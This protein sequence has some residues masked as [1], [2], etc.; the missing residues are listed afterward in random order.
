[1]M[2][3]SFHDRLAARLDAQKQSGNLKE[4]RVIASAIAPSINIGEHD[5]CLLFATND[6]LSL[7]DDPRVKAASI[8]A[9]ERYGAG[10][11]AA[12]FISG[13]QDLHIAL[14]DALASFLQKERAISFI[15]G[16]SANTGIMPALS[17]P[18]DVIFADQLNHASLIDGCRLCPKGVDIVVY[19]HCDLN[20]LRQKIED[21]PATGTRFIVTDG[22]FSM[23]GNAAPLAALC[24]LARE[25]GAVL[26]VDDAHG[27]GV[28]GETGR[29]AAELHGCLDQVDIITGSLGKA[30]GGA[31]GGFVA[32]SA[33]VVDTLKEFAR[34]LLFSNAQSPAVVAATLEAI[35]LLQSDKSMI[36]ELQ[37]RVA[38][39]KALC[40]E[41]DIPFLKTDSAIVSI[42]IGQASRAK[43]VSTEL[44]KR[45]VFVTPFSYP[46]VPEGQ[47]RLRFQISRRQSDD[48]LEKAITALKACLALHPE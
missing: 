28:V 31:P 13:T 24:D 11:A 4:Q 12:R 35:T 2:D 37:D 21:H 43:A 17:A 25:K 34:P 6:Y 18:G 46:V 10:T 23:E 26:I 19:D 47:A 33:L 44:F 27:I 20:N 9:I 48:N 41:N 32:G 29:G 16:W 39:F 15:S 38:T 14:E 36:A 5:K 8:K 1:M 3:A 30:L 22:V 42:P 7:C 40:K 45:G